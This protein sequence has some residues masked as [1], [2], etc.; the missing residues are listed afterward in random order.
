MI[1][2]VVPI[3][4][5]KI[6]INANV[7]LTAI[8]YF[9]PMMPKALSE[10]TRGV[11]ISH[12]ATNKQCEIVR[13][14]SGWARSG[15]DSVLFDSAYAVQRM[16]LMAAQAHSMSPMQVACHCNVARLHSSGVT[17]DGQIS[18]MEDTRL[19]NRTAM[20][21]IQTMAPVN[22]PMLRKLQTD[23]HQGSWIVG[24]PA[25]L[26]C[27]FRRNMKYVISGDPYPTS[28]PPWMRRA[29]VR[30]CIDLAAFRNEVPLI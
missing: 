23:F 28:R 12:D 11:H 2:S 7:E 25:A 20:V 19:P 18:F 4:Y 13:R 9:V 24:R 8:Q 10:K 21:T 17:M 26:R 15:G 6:E 29:V 22:S 14:T 30:S 16:M 27:A 3:I 1:Q 5:A